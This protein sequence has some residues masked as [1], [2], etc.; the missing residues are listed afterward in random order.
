MR[1]TEKIEAATA[2]ALKA[3]KR[4]ERAPVAGFM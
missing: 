2:E 4:N 1:T 3:P